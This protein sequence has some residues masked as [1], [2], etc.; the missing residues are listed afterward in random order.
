MEIPS[1]K[2]FKIINVPMDGNCLFTSLAIGLRNLKGLDIDAAYVRREI[3]EFYIENLELQLNDGTLSE[4]MR[5]SEHCV[6]C[7]I[8]KISKNGE[9]GSHMDTVM[10]SLRFKIQIN[11][12][13]FNSEKGEFSS[14]E[15]ISPKNILGKTSKKKIGELTEKIVEKSINILW[16]GKDHYDYLDI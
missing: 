7:Y 14:I 9:W 8:R 5:R 2:Y 4:W 13:T 10:A 12:W 11:I 3:A 6:N 16:N 15:T 1:E